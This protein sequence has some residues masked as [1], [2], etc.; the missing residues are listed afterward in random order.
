MFGLIGS[1]AEWFMRQIANLIYVGSTPTTTLIFSEKI[2]T[3]NRKR[4]F[5]EDLF[6]KYENMH[7]SQFLIK[8]KINEKP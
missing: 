7:P 3:I 8:N 5:I 6:N 4:F 2:D 1:M